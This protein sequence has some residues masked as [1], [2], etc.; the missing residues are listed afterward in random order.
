MN[1]TQI[2]GKFKF[3]GTNSTGLRNPSLYELYG[4]DN[5]GIGGNINLKPEKSKTN[6]I[7]AEYNFSENIEN[8]FQQPIRTKIFDR[9]ESNSAYTNMKMN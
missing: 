4:S 7:Y 6:E 3:G 5:Y 8:L 1:F 2:L 9:I